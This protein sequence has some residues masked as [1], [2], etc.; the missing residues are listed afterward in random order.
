MQ[1][2]D[3]NCVG[4]LMGEDLSI[5]SEGKL[6]ADSDHFYNVNGTFKKEEMKEVEKQDEFTLFVLNI[7]YVLLTRGVDGV[8]IGFWHNEKL[9]QY[10]MDTLDIK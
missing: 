7:Y 3:L 9:R 5:T 6:K 8:R 2:I 1:G 4:V 10:V